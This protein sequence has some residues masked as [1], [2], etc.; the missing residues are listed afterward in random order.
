MS[1]VLKEMLRADDDD[2]DDK[3]DASAPIPMLPLQ[4]I[5]RKTLVKVMEFCE[6]HAED[7]MPA[8]EVPIKSNVMSEILKSS[9]WDLTYVEAFDDLETLVN[10]VLAAKY[11]DID[12]LLDLGCVKIAA[13]IRGKTPKEVRAMFGIGD[14]TKE[15]E[16]QIRRE[17]PWIFEISHPDDG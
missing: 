4:N 5:D 13:L 12:P 17:N 10:V 6:R 3:G 1:A 11:L 9:P 14:I 8:I 2:D 15:E 7:P 16:D